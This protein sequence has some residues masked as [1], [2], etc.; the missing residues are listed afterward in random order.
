MPAKVSVLPTTMLLCLALGAASAAAD[1][2]G[3][4]PIFDGKTLAGWDGNPDLWSVEESAITGRTSADKPI[5]VN[6]FLI[7]RQGELD[8]FELK[9][10]YRMDG[11]NSG[12]QYRSFEKPDEWG[13][14]VVGGYQADIDATDNYTGIM[15]GERYRGILAQRGEKSVVGDDH[16][17]KPAEK[18]AESA[19]L[20][21]AIRSGDW[22]NYHIIARGHRFQHFINGKL[23]SETL[24][25]DKTE[26]RRGGILAFQLH[27]GPPMKIQFRDIRLKRLPMEGTKKVVFIAGAPSHGFAAHEHR[28]GCM[29]LARLL[30]Q[31]APGTYAAT[32]HYDWPA[33]PT[34]LDNADAVV[35]FA[36]GAEGNPLLGHEAEVGKLMDRGVGLACLHWATDMP[37]GKPGDALLGWLGGRFETDWSVNPAWKAEFR[38]LPDHPIAR[39]VRP[40]SLFDEWYYHMRFVPEVTS[41]TPILTAVP[42]DKTRQRED[43]PY[44]G[45]PHVRA[46]MGR[47]EVVAWAYDRASRGGKGRSFGFTGGHVHWNWANDDFRRLVLNGIVWITGNDVPAEGVAS[48]RPSLEELLANQDETPPAGFKPKE[49]CKQWG[50]ATTRPID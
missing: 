29:L 13:R 44:S 45:N 15:Y 2:T 19:D 48:D 43:G 22:N 1:D 28:A 26:R 21:A 49:V 31:N 9:C 37:K 12:I 4:V 18:F 16:K 30:K 39:G 33:D 5:K 17:P 3:F 41:V 20:K 14:W 46:R 24:D 38:A 7:W 11:G 27:V 34:A 32:Y 47:P 23:M 42:P 8:D 6:T 10:E 25:E 40:F 36:N 35:V 50:L